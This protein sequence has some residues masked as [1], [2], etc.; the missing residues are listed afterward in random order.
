MKKGLLSIVSL[1]SLT[2]G[3]LSAT[4]SFFRTPLSFIESRW[5]TVHY[6]LPPLD[7]CGWQV[8]TMG[9]VYQRS[10]CDAFGRDPLCGTNNCKNICDDGNDTST[11]RKTVPLSQLWFGKADFSARDIGFVSSEGNPFLAFT[12]FSPRF[13][14][15]ENGVALALNAYRLVGCDKSWFVG[16]R[17]A[18]PICSIQVNEVASVKLSTITPDFEDTIVPIQQQLHG[19]SPGTGSVDSRDVKAYRLDFLSTLEMPDGT[20]MVE[21]GTVTG[22]ITGN[23]RIAGQDITNN[24]TQTIGGDTNDRRAPVYVYKQSSGI[25]PLPPKGLTVASLTGNVPP[26]GQNLM[27][28]SDANVLLAADGSG[29]VD[30]QWAAFGGFTPTPPGGQPNY[31]ADYAGNLGTNVAAQK[32]LFVV[33]VGTSSGGTTFE[34]IGLVV[35]NTI[36]YVI[37]KLQLASTVALDFFADKGYSLSSCTSG[38]GDT[39]IDFYGGK[40]CDCWYGDLLVGLRLPTGTDSDNQKNLYQQM[41]GNNGH[42]GLKFGVEG[43]YKACDWMGIKGDVFWRHNFRATEKRAA[44][45]VGST[46]HNFGPC[47]DAQVKWNDLQAHVD[48][49]V[50]LPKCPNTGWDVGYEFYYRTKDDLCYCATQAYNLAG[51]LQ[52]LDPNLAAADSKLLSHKVRFEVFSQWECVEAFLGASYIFAGDNVMKEREWHIGMKAYF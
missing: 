43:G 38:A 30:G 44:A 29:P 5:G 47:I 4:T 52:T 15:Y 33:P 19:T 41:T 48:V 21:Y 9:L 2:A 18:L 17:A 36:D 49:T 51:V 28:S 39:F 10:A 34:P 45:F 46:V 25:V 31:Q 40:W 16:A 23:T 22:D 50:F 6:P 37:Q 24:V 8:D 27:I 13:R 32:Q 11:T 7:N 42:F 35:Q 20:P 12:N 14:Y 26:T 1:L 3:P